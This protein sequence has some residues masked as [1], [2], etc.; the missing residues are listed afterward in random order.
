METWRNQCRGK[1]ACF[2]K[3]EM[4]HFLFQVPFCKLLF[5]IERPDKNLDNCNDEL[6]LLH[7]YPGRT[8][9]D[10]MKEPDAFGILK[11]SKGEASNLPIS[12]ISKM[13]SP[14]IN[15]VKVIIHEPQ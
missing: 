14:L 7:C 1:L 2:F 8:N 5:N 3:K 11:I 10:F 6:Y 13:Q 15:L 4:V 12:F 9:F